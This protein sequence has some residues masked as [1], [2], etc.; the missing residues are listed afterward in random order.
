[1]MS[2]FTG[3]QIHPKDADI[4]FAQQD[5]E[6]RDQVEKARAHREKMEPLEMSL[7]RENQSLAKRRET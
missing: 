3:G 5:T 6:K 1:M 7:R 4:L 2:F